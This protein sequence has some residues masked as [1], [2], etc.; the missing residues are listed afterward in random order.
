LSGT[1]Q[2]ALDLI[3]QIALGP[4]DEVDM[5]GRQL[6]IDTEVGVPQVKDEQATC[7]EHLQNLW[8][9]ALVVSLGVLL[10][11]AAV[12]ACLARRFRGC[13]EEDRKPTSELLTKFR[14][15]ESRGHLSDAEY[16]TIKTVLAV[17]LREELNGDDEKG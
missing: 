15:M 16:R 4:S 17:P 6:G 8:P 10:L 9:E 13:A 14:E 2:V 12:G 7:L 3:G 11:F 1:L 5:S